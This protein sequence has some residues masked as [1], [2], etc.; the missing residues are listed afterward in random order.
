MARGMGGLKLSQRPHIFVALKRVKRENSERKGP[1]MRI[2]KGTLLMIDPGE[3]GGL[4]ILC[5]NVLSGE[6]G[7]GVGG[8][9]EECCVNVRCMGENL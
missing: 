4:S 9:K 6:G 7:N 3:G 8:G 2:N 1:H 5:F